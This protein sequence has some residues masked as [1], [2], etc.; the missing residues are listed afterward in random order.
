MTWSDTSMGRRT[1]KGEVQPNGASGEGEGT[2]KAQ[3][4]TVSSTCAS[5]C[6][7]YAGSA[8]VGWLRNRTLGSVAVGMARLVWRARSERRGKQLMGVRGEGKEGELVGELLR[9]ARR[10][11][12]TTGRPAAR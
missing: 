5:I 10:R 9:P 8:D 7:T 12:P 3:G 4:R 1:R 2:S 11:P 6:L